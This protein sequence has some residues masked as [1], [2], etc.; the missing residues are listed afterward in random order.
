MD[1]D[2]KFSPAFRDREERGHQTVLFAMTFWSF[3]RELSAA[4]KGMMIP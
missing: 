2:A 1:R 4:E 3:L